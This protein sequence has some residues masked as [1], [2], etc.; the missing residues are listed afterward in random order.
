MAIQVG[1]ANWVSW[2]PIAI[3]KGENSGRSTV[4]GQKEQNRQDVSCF[5]IELHALFLTLNDCVKLQIAQ[6]KWTKLHI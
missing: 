2:S 1:H 3:P 4:V 5:P 6:R